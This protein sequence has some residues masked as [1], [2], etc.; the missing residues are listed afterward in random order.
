VFYP[1]SVLVLIQVINKMDRLALELKL[2]PQDAYFKITHTLEEVNNIIIANTHKTDLPQR[3]SPELGNVCFAAG[4]HGWSFTLAS[5]AALY[6]ARHPRFGLDPSDLAK[7]L[8]GD[9]FFSEEKNA[10]TRSKPGASAVRTFV[11]YI[12]EPLYKIYAHLIG[13]TPEDL[14]VVFKQLGIRMKGSE[15]H[16]DP[17]PLLRLALSRF[18]GKPSGFVNMVV[19]CVPSPAD[20][21]DLK[22]SNT[23][24]G[25]LTS[26]LAQSMRECSSSAPLMCNV[27]KLYNSPDGTR[28]H[29][30]TRIYSGTVR[31]GQRVKV[32]GESFTAED[33]EDMAVVEVTGISV[34]VG[35]FFLEVG[36]ATAGNWVL[37]EGVDGPIKK[38]ATITDVNTDDAYIFRPL[39]FDNTSVFKLA[40]EPF[41][42][43]ELPKMVEALRRIN[44]TYPLV[45]T[46]VE[47][48]GEH[49]ILGTGELYMDCVMHDLRHLYSDIEVRVAD[50]VVSFCETVVESSALNCF[51]ET[52]NKKNR[53]T[54][55]AEPLDTGLAADIERGVVDIAWDKKTIG[56]FFRGK[57]DWDLLSAR[58]IWA[59]GAENN[60]PNLLLNNTLPSE[61]DQKLLSTVK[62]SVVQ[63]FKWGCRE[64]PLCDEPMRN[65]KF[66]IL[67]ASVARE[68]IHRGGGQV[69]PTAR[70]TAYSAFLMATPRYLYVS[71]L[72][73]ERS[74][75]MLVYRLMEPMY[76]VEIQAPADC[77]QAIYPVLAR[78]RGHIVQDAPKPGT[79]FYTLKAYIPV[80]DRCG[81]T[82]PLLVYQS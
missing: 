50:P 15:L 42:P 82:G 52:P 35:R 76:L 78:R 12:L 79:P 69:I 16:L 33:D 55:L 56:E 77:V 26:P 49:V 38:T 58:N 31:V 24:T 57:Y 10:F 80:M 13:E 51:A 74:S 43:S 11:Q 39:Q 44:K 25:Y 41:N 67:D 61:V 71:C 8:W 60:G 17:R 63:G 48:S 54:M 73:H 14:L 30:L 70:R 23:Y 7:R 19:Q 3:I 36:S 22:V 34:S 5:F 72:L 37:L 18:F 40:V 9:W 64:G 65:V 45:T 62:D 1:F 81:T 29:A 6:C 32:L 21:A 4:Q 27:V 46:K 53:L 75:L 2:P 20:S 66:K 59:F 68:P 28:F 47:E